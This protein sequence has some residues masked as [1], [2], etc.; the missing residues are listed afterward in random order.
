MKHIVPFKIFEE[1]SSEDIEKLE[2]IKKI[3]KGVSSRKKYH[4]KY[5]KIFK[6][7]T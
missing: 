7:Y 2:N 4:Q 3:T 6:K 5:K 1:V